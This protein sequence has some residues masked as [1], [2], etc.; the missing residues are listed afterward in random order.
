[1]S[2][3]HLAAEQ[4]AVLGLESERVRRALGLMP[5][6]KELPGWPSLV[7]MIGCPGSGKDTWISR[8]LPGMISIS[9][10]G[11]RGLCSPVG[12]EADQSVTDEAVTLGLNVARYLLEAGLSVVWNATNAEKPHRLDLLRLAAEMRARPVAVV[13]HPPLAICLE[14]NSQ[15][16][17][18]PGLSGFAR[19]VPAHVIARM[20]DE[21]GHSLGGLAG[22]GWHQLHFTSPRVVTGT[23]VD[24][25]DAASGKPHQFVR[26]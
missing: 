23:A 25:V 2:G 1:M 17:P 13:L 6:R 19:R 21:I 10:D 24:R 7:T 5:S 26:L 15:R 16:D 4:D 3:R 11:L 8:Y 18:R 20:H 22:E 14:R 12:D 9:L